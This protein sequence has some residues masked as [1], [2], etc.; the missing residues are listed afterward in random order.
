MC[1]FCH[2]PCADR[3]FCNDICYE[4]Y[5]AAQAERLASYAEE[6]PLEKADTFDE[7]PEHDVVGG[8]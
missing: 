3:E 8:L 1:L 5:Q 7:P 2:C 6:L 4:E